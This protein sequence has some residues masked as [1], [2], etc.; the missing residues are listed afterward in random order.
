L[1]RRQ[2]EPIVCELET[3]H[4]DTVDVQVAITKITGRLPSEAETRAVIRALREQD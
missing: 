2:I 4:A 1:T 3:Q